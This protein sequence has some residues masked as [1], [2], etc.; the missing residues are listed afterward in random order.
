MTLYQYSTSSYLTPTLSLVG[1]GQVINIAPTSNLVSG[2]QYQVYVTGSVQNT[3]GLAVQAYAYNFTA[4][5][6]TD[7][8]APTITTVAPPNTSTN[9][10]TNA[11]RER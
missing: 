5:T 11:R 8:A 4:G 7:T 1:G 9:I 3:D 2:S 10:G 6:A